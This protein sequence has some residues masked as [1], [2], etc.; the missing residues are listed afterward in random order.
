MRSGGSLGLSSALRDRRGVGKPFCITHVR[1]LEFYG[2]QPAVRTRNCGN[3]K[4]VAFSEQILQLISLS[5]HIPK[6]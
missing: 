1:R 5:E 4:K 6:K 3:N 2:L